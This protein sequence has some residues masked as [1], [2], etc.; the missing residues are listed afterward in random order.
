[1]LMAHINIIQM[2]MHKLIY[3]KPNL[4]GQNYKEQR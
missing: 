1:M 2:F 4:H 3:R